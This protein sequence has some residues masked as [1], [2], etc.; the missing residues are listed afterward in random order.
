MRELHHYHS[1]QNA[2]KTHIE[3]SAHLFSNVSEIDL[4]ENF[5]HLSKK[6]RGL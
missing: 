3:G 5:S 1:T 2:E 6:R 4:I